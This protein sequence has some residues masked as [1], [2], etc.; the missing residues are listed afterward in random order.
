MARNISYL[1]NG[2]DE[3]R[4]YGPL[5][6][7]PPLDGRTW[8]LHDKF[9]GKNAPF[10]RDPTP[11]KWSIQNADKT[12]YEAW[13]KEGCAVRWVNR[14]LSTRMNS[15]SDIT[16]INSNSKEKGGIF[17]NIRVI[18]SVVERELRRANTKTS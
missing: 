12:C 14:M 10:N 15:S 6:Q 7:V 9:N 17:E 2:G 16:R 11:D 8:Y 3:R 5:A 1:L 13:G 18:Q 4:G